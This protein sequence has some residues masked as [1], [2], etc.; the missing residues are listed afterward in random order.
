MGADRVSRRDFLAAAGAGV[1]GAASVFAG[2]L[3]A[4]R[5]HAAAGDP[6][7][8]RPKKSG[9]SPG[10][11]PTTWTMRQAVDAMNR[12]AISSVELTKA[13]LGRIDKLNPSLNAFITV[14][15]E[16]ALASAR[17]LDADRRS[18]KRRPTAVYGIPIALKDNIDT[19]G[20]R[21]T[22]ASALYEDRV[23]DADAEVVRRL[24]DA[25]AV[26]LGK[27]NLQEFA[28]GG[29]STVSHF[30]PVHNPVALDRIAGGSSGGSAAAVAAGL[31]FAA[32]GTDTAGSIRLPASFCGNVGLK[33]TYGLVSN[34]GVIPLSWTHDHVG[35]ITRTV[36]DAFDVLKE[37]A[38]YD[39]DD[40]VS[41]GIEFK[42]F[43]QSLS[44]NPPRRLGIPRRP[45]FE[46]LHPDVE[47]SVTAAVDAM[48]KRGAEIIEVD[49]PPAGLRSSGLYVRVRGP[50][51]YAFHA[52]TLAESPGKYQDATRNALL[53]FADAKIDDYI[54]ARREVEL[55]RRTI[56]SSFARVD[57][58]VTPTVPEPPILISEANREN[59]VDWKNTVP[60]STY[61]LPAVSVPCG[62]T[63]DGLPIGLQIA[64]PPFAEANVLALAADVERS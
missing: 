18:G 8:A 24:K 14:T 60:F 29:T 56:L 13:C 27:T 52:R 25:G 49:L 3:D 62:R 19:A 46:N 28:F 22:A 59:P 4:A 34:R 57:L 54:L 6:A 7:A 2:D 45:F 55:L 10:S 42:G 47:R 53:K 39:A 51:A 15:A 11:D 16:E 37:I 20:V 44:K 31:C 50:E 23:P 38:G 32:I 26:I 21:T 48:A 12:G 35:P 61:G 17:A 33:P 58:L 64:G 40:P 30:G 36:D 5:A 63:K 1:A 41:T 9:S 43:P